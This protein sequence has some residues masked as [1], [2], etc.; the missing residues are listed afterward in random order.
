MEVTVLG[1]GVIGLMTARLLQDR[2]SHVTLVSREY[3]NLTTSRAASGIMLP[4]FPFPPESEEFSR[5]LRWQEATLNFLRSYEGGRFLGTVRHTEFFSHGWVEGQV[6]SEG[7]LR[8][9]NV[10]APGVVR[11][12]PSIM[13]FDEKV[14]FEMNF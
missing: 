8:Y 10:K 6:R 7:M 5:R 4:T 2:G 13:G 14:S 11:L 9:V 12:N 3:P 1:T